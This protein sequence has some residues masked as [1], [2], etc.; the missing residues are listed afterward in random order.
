MK[1]KIEELENRGYIANGIEQN[2]PDASFE[3]RKKLLKSKFPCERTLGARLLGNYHDLRAI[4]CL[5][6]AFIKEKKLYTKIEI[7][8]SLVSY[9][10]DAVI[11]LIQLLG[12]IGNNQHTSIPETEFKKKSYPLPRD[13]AART[14]IRIGTVVL[15]DLVNALKSKD[16]SLL[17]ELIDAIGYICF[18]NPQSNL[19][20]ELKDCFYRN[21]KNELI[22]WKLFRAMSAF[23]GGRLFLSGQKEN[24]GRLKCEIERSL[25]L[26][27]KHIT[28]KAG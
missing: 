19:F 13:I 17:S 14:L 12:K 27:R 11:P 23:P 5:I 15:P 16:E 6:D 7:S 8:N 26:L 24:S 21:E 2:Y 25:I 1:S 9:G 3:Q 18:Y 28:T 10:K 4:D 20:G 22:K